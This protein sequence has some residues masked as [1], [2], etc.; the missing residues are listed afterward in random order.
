MLMQCLENVQPSYASLTSLSVDLDG[1]VYFLQA[2]RYDDLDDVK[3]LAS[4]GVS[5]DSKDSLGR[6]GYEFTFWLNLLTC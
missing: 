3:S 4:A 1:D 6:T 2:A 5:L